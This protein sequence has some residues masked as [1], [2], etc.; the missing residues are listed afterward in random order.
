MACILGSRALEASAD[1]G[2]HR[3]ARTDEEHG[4][5]QHQDAVRRDGAAA[6]VRRDGERGGDGGQLLRN[7]R[8]PERDLQ[9]VAARHVRVDN[10]RARARGAAQAGVQAR[11]GGQL[12]SAQASS[13]T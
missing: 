7:R 11:R 4:R 5:R 6:E 8:R 2:E 1:N 10:L 13:A 9:V 12:L 3:G